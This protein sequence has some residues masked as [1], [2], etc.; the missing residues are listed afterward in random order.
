MTTLPGP[1][2]GSKSHT[3]IAV[4]GFY[5]QT[6]ELVWTEDPNGNWKNEAAQKSV[7]IDE[8]G[9]YF[10]VHFHDLNQDQTLDMMAT[11]WSRTGELGQSMGY[12]LNAV[13]WREPASWL[14]HSIFSRFPQFLNAGFGSP[15][16]FSIAV[17]L[18]KVLIKGTD[19]LESFACLSQ[20]LVS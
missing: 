18:S 19:F 20:Q 7:L 13:D 15:G 2:P 16:G 6:L 9:W 12:A 17:C 14:K 10:D 8:A 4:G 3:V 5:S 1:T 11:T